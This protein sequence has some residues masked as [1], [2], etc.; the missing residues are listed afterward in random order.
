LKLAALQDAPEDSTPGPPTPAG[1][2]LSE[3]S[4]A[5]RVWERADHAEVEALFGAG[6]R[7]AHSDEGGAA[8]CPARDSHL[9]EFLEAYIK[10]GEGNL[11]ASMEAEFFSTTP[12]GNY[13]VAVDQRPDSATVGKIIGMVG[14]QCGPSGAAHDTEE[15]EL[16][17]MSIHRSARGLGLAM[18]LVRV[19]EEHARQHGFKRIVLSTGFVMLPAQRL[20]EKF[21]FRKD[22][23]RGP[24]G[25][26][27]FP[28]ELLVDWTGKTRDPS[29]D[30]LAEIF[31][32]KDT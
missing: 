28:D 11:A 30:L 21:D 32:V 31:Y 29:D 5:I 25:K 8:P 18:R 7:D 2:V 20:Y 23:R 26:S 12:P 16:R 24:E 10:K 15:L 27:L 19:V 17:R 3:G 4:V 14:A 1:R 22:E 6:M 13:W 9:L